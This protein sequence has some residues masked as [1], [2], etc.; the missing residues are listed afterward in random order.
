MLGSSKGHR[1]TCKQRSGPCVAAT[2]VCPPRRPRSRLPDSSRSRR[3]RQKTD[4][5]LPALPD[6]NRN[7]TRSDGRLRDPSPPLGRSSQ[8]ISGCGTK[9]DDGTDALAA[10]DRRDAAIANRRVRALRVSVARAKCHWPVNSACLPVSRS[11]P[12]LPVH[13]SERV[14]PETPLN[15]QSLAG[16]L[17]PPQVGLFP[18]RSHDRLFVGQT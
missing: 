13:R 10:G 1:T 4:E 7:E 3:A 12:L 8:L 5:N 16:R 14:R 2:R 17:G 15:P 18:V 11:S 6:R 9:G